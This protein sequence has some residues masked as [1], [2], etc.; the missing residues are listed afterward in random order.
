MY[1]YLLKDDSGGDYLLISLDEK[2]LSGRAEEFAFGR[3]PAGV[4]LL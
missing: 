3:M 4:S 1:L 2:A